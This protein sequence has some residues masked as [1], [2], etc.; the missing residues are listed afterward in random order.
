MRYPIRFA[1]AALAV[2]GFTGCGGTDDADAPA[3]ASA[4]TVSTTPTAM[5]EPEEPAA[6]AGPQVH[7]GELA[8]GD[9]TL[10]TGEY[11][12]SYGLT[13]REGQTVIVDATTD[14]E[15]DPYVILR[16]PNGEQA[17]NDDVEGSTTHARVEHVATEAGYYTA[18]VTSYESGESG[19]YTVTLTVQE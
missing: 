17:E 11:V 15:L 19:S 13:V 10:E 18:M 16:A 9:E 6:P 8:A 1:L 3:E 4:E 7:T 5:S 14:G 12:D 2:L